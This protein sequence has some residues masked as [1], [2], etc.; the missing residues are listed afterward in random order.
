MGGFGGVGGG[1]VVGVV[2][3]EE[4]VAECLEVFEGGLEGGVEGA[5]AAALFLGGVFGFGE[6]DGDVLGFE[7]EFEVRSLRAEVGVF[8][9]GAA[10]GLRGVVVEDGK[11]DGEGE[12]ELGV[13]GLEWCVLEEEEGLDVLEEGWGEGCFGRGGADAVGMRVWHVHSTFVLGWGVVELGAVEVAEIVTGERLVFCK[14]LWGLGEWGL[15]IL[16]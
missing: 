4:S 7:D 12:F 15:G 16:W 1:G 5:E 2:F 3:A 11:E 13:E 9:D 10:E 8:V 14:W 6:G